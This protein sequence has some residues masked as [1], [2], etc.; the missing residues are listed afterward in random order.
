MPI[1]PVA[2]AVGVHKLHSNLITT[3]GE[4][5]GFS[6]A[7]QICLSITRKNTRKCFLEFLIFLSKMSKES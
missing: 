2:W 3:Q 4:Y 7:T 5:V 1:E 6:W